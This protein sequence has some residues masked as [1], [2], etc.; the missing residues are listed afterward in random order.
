MSQIIPKKR[1]TVCDVVI[2]ISVVA[3]TALSFFLM[4]RP[5]SGSKSVHIITTEKDFYVDLDKDDEFDLESNGFSYTVKIA[6]GSVSVT[7]ADC[8]DGICRNTRPI[9]KTG[10]SIVCLP[11]KLIIECKETEG[12]PNDADIVVP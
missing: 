4:T 9:G 1:I 8:P 2:I 11:G 12:M 6:D 7:E 10:G 3:L 5:D